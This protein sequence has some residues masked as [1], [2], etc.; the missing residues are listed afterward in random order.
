MCSHALSGREKAK[1]IEASK[2]TPEKSANSV[3][4][5]ILYTRAAKVS[6]EGIGRHVKAI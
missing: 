1:G 5:E 4:V 6:S 3:I 2:L